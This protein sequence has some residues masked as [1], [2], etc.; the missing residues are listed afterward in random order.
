MKV[1]SPYE[2]YPP[3]WGVFDQ[4]VIHVGAAGFDFV[5][6]AADVNR[7]GAR[8]RAAKCFR[9]VEFEG[10][11]EAT[12]DGYSAL[13]Q[14]LL[15][16]SA[17]EH[18]LRCVGIGLQHSSNLLKDDERDRAIANLRKLNGQAEFFTVIRR[19]LNQQYQRQ[20][21]S[22]VAGRVCNP[23]YLAGGIRHAFAHGML[24]ATPQHAPPRSVATVSRFLC[25]VLMKTMDK[26]FERR[27]VEF[28]QGLFPDDDD[29]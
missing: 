1:P 28:E 25:R 10:V 3:R 20:I 23:F 16:Y 27:M 13:C 2:N 24:T 17:F 18:F 7:F 5:G 14:M 26:E 22:H 6:S 9:R 11:V 21:D 12:A 8:Y 29:S 19:Y 4:Y 15:T